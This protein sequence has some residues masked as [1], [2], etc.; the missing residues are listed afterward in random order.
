MRRRSPAQAEPRTIGTSGGPG[1]LQRE[2]R[3]LGALLGQVILEQAG[4]AVL[5]V[6]EGVRMDSIVA[7][8]REREGRVDVDVAGLDGATLESVVRAFGLYFQLA[9]LAEQRDRVR[10]HRR[11]ARASRGTTEGRAIR[12]AIRH[13]GGSDA[14]PG[15][16][17]HLSI[18]PVL[19][20]HPTEARRRTLLLALRRIARALEQFD[21]PR[22][23]PSADAELRRR[24]REEIALLWHTA[25]I[26]SGAPGPLDE[27]RT[28]MVS[29][30][31]TL[32]RLAP[33]VYR[34]V[35]AALPGA[36][37]DRGRR[38]PRT[39]AFLHMGSWIGGDRDGH[40]DVTAEITDQ[41]IQIQSD[42]VLRGHE[43][44]ATRLAQTLA[45]RVA[46]DDVPP[47]LRRRLAEDAETLPDLDRSLRDRY[48]DEPFRQRFGFMV[49]R[50]RRTRH[51]LTQRRGPGA[52]AYE[53]PAEVLTELSEIQQ[54]LVA[55][56][57]ARSAWGEVQDLRW[58]LETFGFHLAA[59]EVR[60]HASVHARRLDRRPTA[61]GTAAAVADHEVDE[62][63]RVIRRVQDRLG[64]AALSRYV[65]SF[66]E[67][68]SDATAVLEI[69]E[70]ACG[71]APPVLDVVPLLESSTSLGSA[72]TF[73]DELLSD[74]GYREH[75]RRRGDRQEVM[76]G[77]SDS[78]KESGYLAANWLLHGAQSELVATARRH[79]VQLTIFHGR[80]G[81]I[82]RGGGALEEALRGQPPGSI[83]LRLKVTEQGEVISA[84]YSDPE[85]AI[86]HLETLAAATI[87]A[88]SPR[89]ADALAGAIEEGGP[90]LDELAATAAAAYRA[91]VVDDPEFPAFFGRITPIDEIATLRLGSRPA[92][93]AGAPTT[94]PGGQDVPSATTL[95]S[96]RAIPW[97][98]AWSQSR[99]ELPGWFGVGGA[100]EAWERRHGEAG[101]D[102]LRDLAARWPFLA[103]LLGHAALSIDRSDLALARRYAA[104]ASEPGDAA[105]WQAIEQEHGRTERMLER[106]LG[107]AWMDRSR[108]ARL[109]APYV[110][111]L[112]A[113]QLGLLAELRRREAQD[114][115]DPEVEHL[116]G[117]V[118]LTISGL[119]AALQGTG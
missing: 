90:I 10:T 82:G 84:R 12:E 95:A 2:V 74:P 79:D 99:V 5:D 37:T 28:A 89:H 73:L 97:V 61:A 67:Q 43:A 9:N 33:R 87:E 106:V 39:P 47:A 27:V 77:Y 85:I 100:L 6:V 24:L 115:E 1:I 54:A 14:V 23:T 22:L 34:A 80:G 41:A 108:S 118:R 49:E 42:H 111:T 114:P 26:R 19:T 58:Q 83:G 69:A 15:I 13:S 94:R 46:P 71:D 45:A 16:L 55:V 3:L 107:D 91:L 36:R 7:R 57:L 92:S 31:E 105:R 109:R 32:Y 11:R 38:S 30:D 93:R 102:R 35:E 20:A 65:V 56:G 60:Q 119:A 62:V 101:L 103:S 116:R 110:D 76:L 81:A 68:P 104:L 98:F 86:E 21:D 78:N 117:L 59:V 29:F 70:L 64:E 113:A 66:A 4:Q 96:L 44:V 112:S 18:A 53:G 63:F 40:P 51:R 17:E 50:L 52:G 25:E 75:V 72:G 48:P 88:S 8:R